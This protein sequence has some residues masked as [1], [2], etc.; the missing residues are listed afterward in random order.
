MIARRSTRGR[1]G[2]ALAAVLTA[3]A[4]AACDS[5]EPPAERDAGPDRSA[6]APDR[7]ATAIGKAMTAIVAAHIDPRPQA[8][9]S[10]DVMRPL[11]NAWRAGSHKQ[12]TEVDA[13]ALAAD[14][15]TGA[16]AILRHDFLAATQEV[17]LVE[18]RGSGPVWITRAP[19]GERVA[20]SAQRDGEIEFASARGVRGTLDL[21]DDTISTERG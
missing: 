3:A 5:G 15:A 19:T 10:L 12:L 6:A 7:P 1:A 16:F 4:F 18:V 14:R 13:G 20:A 21:S 8:F 11:T 17:T 9:V 2:A